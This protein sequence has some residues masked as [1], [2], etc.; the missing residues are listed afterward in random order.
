M[1]KRGSNLRPESGGRFVLLMLL[2]VV[3]LVIALFR[4]RQRQ[5]TIPAAPQ[6]PQQIEH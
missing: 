3:I 2:I 4:I 5:T 6:S 1:T